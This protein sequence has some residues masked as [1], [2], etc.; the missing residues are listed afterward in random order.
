[1]GANLGHRQELL[2]EESGAI[3][4]LLKHAFRLPISES[5]LPEL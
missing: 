5:K 4:R 2:S 1:M 3:S